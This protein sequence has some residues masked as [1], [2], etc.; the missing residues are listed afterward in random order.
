[1]ISDFQWRE[2]GF[3]FAW[4]YL[5]DADMKRINNFKAE[6]AYMEKDSNRLLWNGSALKKYVSREYNPFVFLFEYGNSDNKQGYWSY[7]HLVLQ[8]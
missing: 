4:D 6:K 5:S 7:E 3:L 1:M 2:F 8:M